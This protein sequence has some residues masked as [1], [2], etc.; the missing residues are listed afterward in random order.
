MHSIH[1]KRTA[2]NNSLGCRQVKASGQACR[3]SQGTSGIRPQEHSVP[4]RRAMAKWSPG[5]DWAARLLRACVLVHMAEAEYH[6][7]FPHV[8]LTDGATGAKQRKMQLIRTRKKNPLPPGSSLQHP[9]APDKAY[10][11]Q[12]NITKMATQVILTSL[13]LSRRTTNIYSRTRHH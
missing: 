8:L 3:S 11:Q 4:F 6:Q 1:D 12:S 2:G 9:P 10:H 5:L 7:M 13:P